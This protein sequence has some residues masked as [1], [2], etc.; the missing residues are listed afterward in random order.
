MTRALSSLADVQVFCVDPLYPRYK[1]LQQRT[2]LNPDYDASYTV[3]GV[4]VEYLQYGALPVVSRVMNGH[5]CGCILT[6][7]LRKFRPNVI[8]GYFLY[9]AGFGA[10]AAAADL[11]IPVIV[12]VLG[13]DLRNVSKFMRMVASRTM[14][15]ASFVVTVSDELRKCAIELGI[16]PGKIRTIHNGCD[17]SIFKLADRAAARAELNIDSG[18]ELV[19][20]AGRLVPTKGLREL[21]QAVSILVPSRPRLRMVCIGD[22]VMEK[23]LRQ[24]ASRP[25]LKDHV[26]FVGNRNPDEVARW[27]AASNVF[28]LPSYSEGCPNVVIEALACGRPVVASDVGG[29]PELMD[30]RCGI[31]VPPRNTRQLADALAKA[32]DSPWNQEEIAG[33][34]SRSWQDMARE[35]F[36]VCRSVV[37]NR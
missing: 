32:L 16:P 26:E 19:V 7:H 31:L 28:C 23:E 10:V 30:S 2:F 11:K 25:D 17:S 29:I 8:I 37:G 13:S 22:G 5:N 27:L 1:F 34:S 14:R 24:L 18:V 21:L 3:P 4:E 12:G 33:S 15:R 6:P 35:A 20:F 9:P 36:D